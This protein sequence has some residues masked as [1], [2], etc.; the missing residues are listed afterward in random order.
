MV[1]REVAALP[2]SDATDLVVK[3]D[4]GTLAG[5]L[6]L[7]PGE[8]GRA[9]LRLDAPD[10]P[11]PAAISAS[12][13]DLEGM[14]VHSIVATDL[15]E[16]KE[17]EHTLEERVRT[18]TAELRVA[19]ARLTESNA[20]LEAFSYSISHDLKAPLRAIHG[21]AQILVDEHA[22]QLDEEG[23]RL[24][25]TVVDNT[26]RMG[27]LIDDILALGGVGQTTLQF[28]TVDIEPMVRAVIREVQT[29]HG[30]RDVEV[31]IV[32]PLLPV[33]GDANLLRQVWLNLIG[34]AFKFTAQVAHPHITIESERQGELVVFRIADNGV[35]F[36]PEYQGKLFGVFQ[37]L[38]GA[39]FPGT[40]IG[41]AIVKRIVT[42]H[43]GWVA[44]EGHPGRGA[45]FSFAL[46]CAA[47]S[48]EGTQ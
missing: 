43:D 38:H 32:G 12:C 44:G 27:E 11:V 19:N 35:G 5:L 24:L 48:K 10:G 31:D 37:R 42:R 39:E 1:G 4:A 47:P 3:A 46:P 20:E 17:A 6:A 13:L 28:D 41:L 33:T 26:V 9:E 16:A 23:V 22:S 29:R 25:R 8:H 18:R 40:G 14:A 30:G 21:F 34:N 45:T 2:G 7:P 36:E 15:T